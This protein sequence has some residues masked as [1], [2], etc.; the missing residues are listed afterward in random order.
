MDLKSQDYAAVLDCGFAFAAKMRGWLLIFFLLPAAVDA[1]GVYLYHTYPL[2]MQHMFLIFVGSLLANAWLLQAVMCVGVSMMRETELPLSGVLSRS[3][4]HLPKLFFSYAVVLAAVVLLA[5]FPLFI[6]AAFFLLW[7]PLFC[8]AEI[9]APDLPLRER[10]AALEDEEDSEDEVFNRE[11]RGLFGAKEVWNLGFLRSAVLVRDYFTITFY[12][13]IVLWAAHVVP[14]ALVVLGAGEDYSFRPL[15]LQVF[16]SSLT[17]AF[18]VAALVG[19]FL[20]IVPRSAKKELSFSEVS[21]KMPLSREGNLSGMPRHLRGV[22]SSLLLLAAVLSTVLI[23]E[24]AVAKQMMPAEVEARVVAVSKDAQQLSVSVIIE[25][26]VR[27][28]RW[29]EFAA[30]RVS[31]ARADLPPEQAEAS[32]PSSQDTKRVLSPDRVYPYRP[33]GTRIAEEVFAPLD[34]PLKVELVFA[35]P[36]EGIQEK[37]R[38]TVFYVQPDGRQA[39]LTRGDY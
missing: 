10:S 21:M 35:L 18:A 30:F 5:A 36:Q 9:F 28:F 34:G 29:L 27:R 15:L 19:V 4:L 26:E 33:D 16:F 23:I 12:M 32:H 13:V 11:Q 14:S 8:A 39:M 37:G 6:V 1:L 31:F 7:A 24:D 38:F 3:L 2:E 17:E 22:I 25:D 20:A